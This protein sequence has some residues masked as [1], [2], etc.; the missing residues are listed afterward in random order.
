ML[1]QLEGFQSAYLNTQVELHPFGKGPCLAMKCCCCGPTEEALEVVPP[2]KEDKDVPMETCSLVCVRMSLT[3]SPS[4]VTVRRREQAV[5][6][7]AGPGE[8]GD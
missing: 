2:L 5:P 7:K 6:S 3:R 4:A 1:E 8:R